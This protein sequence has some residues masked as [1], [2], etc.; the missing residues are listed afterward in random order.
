MKPVFSNILSGLLLLLFIYPLQVNA[1]TYQV[2]VGDM[3]MVSL[4]GEESLEKP[5]AVNREGRILLPEVGLVSVTG[6]TE[7]E[8]QETIVAK[9]NS[10]YRDLG[11]LN[12]YVHKKQLMISV[13]GYV[14]QPGEFILPDNGSVQM[15]LHAAGGLRTGA[16]LDRIQLVRDGKT[17]VFN[18]KSY[19][20]S[21]DKNILPQL[22][23]MDA[24][25]IPASPKIG[26]V[27]VDFDP[28][29]LADAGDAAEEHKAVKVFGEVN[30]PGSFSYRESMN[31]IDLLMRAGGVTRYA[32]VEQIRVI[33]QGNPILFNLK[34]YLD[35]AMKKYYRK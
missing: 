19:L 35:T 5:F 30:N 34:H 10:V 26:N 21:G 27:E 25:F 29:N 6:M 14:N 28:A 4:P 32:G 13:Q 31:I 11:N 9:L 16:Q 20:D 22:K 1:E 24:L 12:V 7:T 18:Y 8:M 17:Q 15:A 3:I 2:Q 23:S 33:S